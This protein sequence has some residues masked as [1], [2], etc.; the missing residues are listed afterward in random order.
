V[1]DDPQH[2]THDNSQDLT[3]QFTWSDT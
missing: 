2:P 1:H 3:R